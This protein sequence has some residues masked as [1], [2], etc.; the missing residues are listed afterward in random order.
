MNDHGESELLRLYILW[1]KYVVRLKTSV[2]VGVDYWNYHFPLF[3]IP[4]R[5]ISNHESPF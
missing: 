1:M 2:V 5:L 3:L 4:V